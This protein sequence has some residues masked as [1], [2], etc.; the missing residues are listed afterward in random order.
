MLSLLR[1]W[2]VANLTAGKAAL[3]A[4]YF[5]SEAKALTLLYHTIHSKLCPILLANFSDFCVS[6]QS[7]AYT[8]PDTHAFATCCLHCLG[9]AVLPAN[10]GT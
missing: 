5:C 7:M 6:V 9:R 3:H 8:S 1:T 10:A 4:R 2:Y